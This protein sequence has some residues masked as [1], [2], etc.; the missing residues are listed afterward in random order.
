MYKRQD[1]RFRIASITKTFTTLALLQQ[2]AAGN[3]SLEDS[4]DKY[5]HE[6][7][8]KDD[9][10]IPWK[11]ITLRS[12]ASQLSGIPRELAFSDL[13]TE[14]DDPT[15]L[16]L[17]I[18]SKKGLPTC[19]Q[20][21]SSGNPCERSDLIARLKTTPPLYAPNQKSTYSNVAFE[22]LGLAV[23]NVTG[24]AYEDVLAQ[25][26][27]NPIGMSNTSIVKPDDSTGAIPNTPDNHWDYRL[28][29]QAPTGA[30]Y[31]SPSDMSKY[32]RYI[33]THYNGLTP[34]L[35]W[36][37]PVSY[38]SSPSTFYGTPW[39][40]F[41]TTRILDPISRPTTFVT[42]G[43]NL[44]GYAS[45]IM[46]VP[47]YDIGITI[48][49]AGPPE[50]LAK[51]KSTVTVPLIRGVDALVADDADKT[52]AGVYTSTDS[53]LNTSLTLAASA[54][55]GLEITSFI[56]NSTDVLSALAP[57]LLPAEVAR[58]AWRAQ[59]VPTL[60]YKNQSAVPPAGE[61]WRST[62]VFNKGVD[63]AKNADVWDDECITDEDKAMYAGMPLTE[64]VFWRDGEGEVEEVE[65]SGFRVK[66]R[67]VEDKEAGQAE[68]EMVKGREDG[69]Q[70]V[71]EQ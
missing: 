57:F 68:S 41:R 56:S 71:L 66:M 15:D 14:V 63:E 64:F 5:V 42:K 65:A 30:L 22:L 34:S 59:L 43:G 6:L 52:Y 25:N 37:H 19:D 24:L 61:L 67:K 4:I 62:V 32:L 8:D 39:E 60:L 31:T 48:L 47:D 38:A 3:L 2:H 17:P 29:V 50:S 16:G 40:I 51:L 35:N 23:E 11:D 69:A 33:L 27:L 21:G 9:F 44:N 53:A 26:I 58:S 70:A 55:H 18:V 1:T 54:A 49:V 45:V 46:L 28:G 13:L 36:L 12:L 20:Y 10:S 7:Q